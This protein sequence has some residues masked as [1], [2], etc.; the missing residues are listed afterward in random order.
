[1][2]KEMDFNEG[3]SFCLGDGAGLEKPDYIEW[4]KRR[5]QCFP[6]M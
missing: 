2:R 3:R 6:C 1:M 4:V 5:R